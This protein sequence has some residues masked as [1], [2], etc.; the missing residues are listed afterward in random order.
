MEIEQK[1]N[2]NLV[3]TTCLGLNSL[4]GSTERAFDK[5]PCCLSS[6]IESRT[7]SS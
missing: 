7:N 6:I 2:N 4:L 3:T 5:D 1:D